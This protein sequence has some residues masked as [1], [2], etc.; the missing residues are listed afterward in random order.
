MES[1]ALKHCRPRDDLLAVLRKH[2]Q[3]EKAG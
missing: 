1:F 3:G 2:W